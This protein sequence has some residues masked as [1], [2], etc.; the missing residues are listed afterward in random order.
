MDQFSSQIR[1]F[2]PI[3]VDQTEVTIYCIAPKGEPQEARTRRIRQY[4]DFF[5]ASG[6]ATP[7]DTEE[8]R[9]TQ[10]GYAGAAHAQWNDLTRGATQWIEGPDED[11]KALGVN[12]I[13]SGARTADEGLFVIQHGQWTERMAEAIARERSLAAAVG[14]E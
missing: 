7:D 11:A 12:P 13:L 10:R 4:E 1:V 8:F 3:S 6:M 5:N 2:R 9:A 14:A